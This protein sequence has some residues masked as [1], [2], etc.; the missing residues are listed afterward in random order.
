MILPPPDLRRPVV[1]LGL[2]TLAAYGGWF[3]GFGVL[4]QPIADD[5][6]W[7]VGMLGA[8]F[9]AAQL[10][11]GLGA[12]LG[13]RLLDRRGGRITFTI[14][15]ALGALCLG[16]ASTA[17]TPLVF[18]AAFAV[19][20]GLAGAMGFYHVT[21][22]AARRLRPDRPAV[23]I[24][25]LTIIGAFASPIFLPITAW[26]VGVHGWRPTLAALAVTT[27]VGLLLGAAIAPGGRADDGL[28]VGPGEHEADVSL[29]AAAALAWADPRV[30]RLLLFAVGYGV[31][32][33]ILLAYQVPT[34]ASLGLPLAT[35]ATLAG[36]RGF[37][38]LL[39]RVG[40][41]GMVQ[42]F[43]S[44]RPLAGVMV[45]AVV[46][47]LLLGGST[48]VVVGAVYAVVGGAALGAHSPLFGIHATSVLPPRHLGALVGAVQSVGGIASAAGPLLGGLVAQATG[49][50][51]PAVVMAAAGFA[52]AGLAMAGPRPSAS[53]PSARRTSPDRAATLP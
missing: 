8:A 50:Y 24:G 10:L 29:R 33:S 31:G 11:A 41:D 38:Q 13:G 40:L 19:G 36:A 4:V 28:P 3:Y 34:M 42:R 46:A 25:P 37:F 32:A 51:L 53:G 1:G 27:G 47:C 44:R 21:M 9:A 17:T 20:G 52:V 12:T 22:A 35:A 15:G 23:V 18:G 49:S 7:T 48:T 43:G 39:G 26:A 45:L 16:V 30:R 14:G 2:V 5:T 6:G